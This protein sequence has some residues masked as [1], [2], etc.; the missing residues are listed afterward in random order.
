LDVSAFT[1]QVEEKTTFLFP[2]TRNPADVQ[3]LLQPAFD[4]VYANGKSI[5]TLTGI[6]EQVNTLLALT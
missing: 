4:D 3:A 6:N 1:R 5:T 2:V